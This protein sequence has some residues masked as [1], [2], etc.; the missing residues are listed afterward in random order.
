[1]QKTYVAKT[2]AKLKASE[3]NWE[4]KW[5]QKWLIIDAEGLVLGRLASIVAKILRGKHKPIFTPNID[6]GDHVVIINADKVKL[7]GNKFEEKPYYW[8]TGFPGGIKDRTA[9]QILEGNNP[10][11]VIE[12]AVTRMISRG[13]LQRDQLLKLH[14]YKG[15]DHKHQGQK[16]E[17]L[18]IAKMNRKNKITN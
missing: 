6:C 10:E 5:E 2:V 1:M 3:N 11:R 9:R 18:D 13:P 12:N 8:H 14:I 7:T 4:K 17:V 15:V 16:P